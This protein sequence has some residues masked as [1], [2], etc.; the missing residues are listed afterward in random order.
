MSDLKRNILNI[1]AESADEEDLEYDMD[2]E[3]EDIIDS[4]VD[5]VEDVFELDDMHESAIIYTEE[6]IPVCQLKDKYIIEYDLLNKY[7]ESNDINS[8]ESLKNICK[9]NNIDI[10]D[11]FVVISSQEEINESLLNEKCRYKKEKNEDIKKQIKKKI[12]NTSK[13]L[14]ELKKNNINLLKRKSCKGKGKKSK[15]KK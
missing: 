11:T 1:L 14:K 5:D 4:V 10:N 2:D 9:Y 7:M 12:K 8:Y 6:M 3:I 13:E 15:C